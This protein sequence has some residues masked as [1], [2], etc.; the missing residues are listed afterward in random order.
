[1]ASKARV[2]G[3]TSQSRKRREQNR[4]K[5]PKASAERLASQRCNE[6]AAEARGLQATLLPHSCC[7]GCP[8]LRL[9]ADRTCSFKRTLC[10]RACG[11]VWVC[12]RLNM[13]ITNTV[14]Q[15]ICRGTVGPPGGGV[16]S[17][18]NRTCCL[19]PRCTWGLRASW[20]MRSG[21]IIISFIFHL[22]FVL[23]DSFASH[24]AGQDPDPR[25]PTNV[26]IPDSPGT[27]PNTDYSFFWKPPLHCHLVFQEWHSWCLHTFWSQTRHR[28]IRSFAKR[29]WNSSEQ[30]SS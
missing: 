11:W 4:L 15:G 21:D 27:A 14:S 29:R 20:W 10:L 16:G 6:A 5:R 22:M 1:M 26:L 8:M 13:L 25:T 12:E 19:H 9:L 3:E 18:R 24:T 17:P 7:C 28:P 2:K 23:C 30:R